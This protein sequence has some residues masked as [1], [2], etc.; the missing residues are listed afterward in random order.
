MASRLAPLTVHVYEPVTGRHLYRLPYTAA[1]WTESLNQPGSMNVTVDYTRTAA[2]LGLFESL[3]CWKALIA[4]QRATNGGF[5]VVHAGP[6]TDWEWDAEN[7]SLKLTVGGGLTLLTKRLVINHALKDSWRD[8]SMLLDE[9]HPAGDMDLTLKGSYAD[10]AR[11]LTAEAMQWGSLPIGLPATTGGDRTRTYYAWDLATC[12]DR[13]LDLT[14]LEHGIEIRFDPRVKPDGSL[15]FDLHA[16]NE[17]I[18]NKHQW[19]AVIPGQRVIL[20]SVAGAGGSMT[21]Q[22][23][24]TGGKDGDKTLMC[25]RTTARL[26]DQGYLFCQSADTTHTTVSDLKTLQAHALG[27]LAQGAFPA[28]T[29]KVKVGEEHHVKVGDHAD[30]RVEDDHLGSRLL[31][32][33]ITDLSGSAD[34]D[35]LT[36]QAQERNDT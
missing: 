19:N 13:I 9:K 31:R 30:L 10:I 36:L 1:D 21:S 6:L 28:E 17:L 33:K 25:R 3:R 5:E 34:S 11:G 22:A 27:D 12:A 2:R 18:D 4:L 24:L 15:I 32:L 29:Y 7:R 26:T 8:G 14:S 35:W 23:W 16:G 20:S